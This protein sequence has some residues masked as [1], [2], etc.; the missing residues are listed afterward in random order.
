MNFLILLTD[1]EPQMNLN[2][3][4][5]LQDFKDAGTNTTQRVFTS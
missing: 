1:K 3:K 5:I 4:S 2:C